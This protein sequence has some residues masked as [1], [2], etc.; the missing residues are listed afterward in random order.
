MT[1]ADYGQMVFFKRGL[2]LFSHQS[3]VTSH[4]FSVR[5]G[6]DDV[7]H[8]DAHSQ[9]GKFLGIARIV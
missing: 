6:V 3:Q 8:A 4:F 7:I 9:V 1:L 2:V 5:H